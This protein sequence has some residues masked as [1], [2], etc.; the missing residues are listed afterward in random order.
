MEYKVILQFNIG[1]QSFN[2]VEN[3]NPSQKWES[4]HPIR[5]INCKFD[6]KVG[7]LKEQ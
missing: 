4:N 6:E 1:V 7:L 5:N 3:N 2:G